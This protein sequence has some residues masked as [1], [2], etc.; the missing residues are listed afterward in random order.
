MLQVFY[1]NI[2]FSSRVLECSMQRGIGVAAVFFLITD[3]WI[4][5]FSLAFDGT[6]ANFQCCIW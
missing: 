1:L 6:N 2:A 4:I 3:G 5:I